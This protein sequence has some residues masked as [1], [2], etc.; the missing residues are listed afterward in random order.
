[1]D[2]VGGIIIPGI[3]LLEFRV[4]KL[5]A[6]MRSQKFWTLTTHAVNQNC[7]Y[8]LAMACFCPVLPFLITG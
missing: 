4:A 5:N 2:L 7:D 8:G 1:L 6:K 3:I